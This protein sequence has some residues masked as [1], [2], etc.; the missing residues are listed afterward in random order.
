MPVLSEEKIWSMDTNVKQLKIK[1]KC[2]CWTN[3]TSKVVLKKT[4]KLKAAYCSVKS[5]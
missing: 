3:N 4:N 2:I 1:S 5:K